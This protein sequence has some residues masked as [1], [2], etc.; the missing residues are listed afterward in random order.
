MPTVPTVVTTL[1][2]GT[3][4]AIISV[5]TTLPGDYGI[6][7]TDA[8]GTTGS[9]TFTVIDMSYSAFLNKSP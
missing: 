8:E 4:T 7:A 9:A 3:F 2:D 6:T 1:D 5:P